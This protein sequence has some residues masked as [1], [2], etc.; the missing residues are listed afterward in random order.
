M[1]RKQIDVERRRKGTGPVG[2]AEEP[3]RER[4]A[5]GAL[6]PGGGLP[7]PPLF[8]GRM[9]SRGVQAGGC[10]TILLIVL[11]IGYYLLTG[12]HGL[13]LGPGGGQPS[14]DQ[15]EP[16]FQQPQAALPT[17]NFTPP[18][19]PARLRPR[20]LRGGSIRGRLCRY[21]R[22]RYEVFV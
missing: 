6:P 5:G 11:A 9:P 8:G 18:P 19:A 17:S 16:G 15:G 2:R 22:A 12:G 3:R 20:D 7:R 21:T 10:G 4:E 1:D 13:N 14:Y